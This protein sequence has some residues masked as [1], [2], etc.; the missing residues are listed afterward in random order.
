MSVGHWQI[1][2]IFSILNRGDDAM[3]HALM[4]LRYA[5]D[6]PPF[7]A[8]YGHES[9][10]RAALLLGDAA[11]FAAHLGLAQASLEQVS[12]AAERAPLAEDL[13]SLIEEAR[14]RNVIA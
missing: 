14:R 7:F 10:A 5:A 9:A 6:C 12:D 1:S 4:A 3:T 2:R 8:G 13:Q 11:G